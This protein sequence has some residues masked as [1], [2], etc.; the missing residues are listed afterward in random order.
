MFNQKVNGILPQ[1]NKVS[2]S[3]PYINPRSIHYCGTTINK[4]NTNGNGSLQS[5]ADKNVAVESF[6]M[7]PI[8]TSNEY[9]SNIKKYLADIVYSDSLELKKSGLASEEYLLIN[10]YTTEPGSSFLQT[11]EEEVV[12]YINYLMS[13]SIDKVDM[14]KEYNPVCEGFI[15][16]DIEIQ[17]Y[18]STSNNNHFHH[19]VVFSAMN[20]TRYNTVSF[21]AELFQDTTGI[22]ANWNKIINNINYKLEKKENVNTILFVSNMDFLNNTTCVLGQESECEFKGYNF[23]ENN[24]NEINKKDESISWLSFGS[25]PDNTYNLDGTYDTDGKIKIVD[26]GPS[27]LDDLLKSFLK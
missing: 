12:N 8:V 26:Q 5:W 6:G 17:S 24:F 14:F 9:F 1:D 4:Y 3:A 7:R 10:D 15:V 21:K 19:K 23:K 20:T 25:L 16:T 13:A 2:Y 22:M 18:Q 27:N 11:I